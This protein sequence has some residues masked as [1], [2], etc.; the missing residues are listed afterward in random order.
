MSQV[1]YRSVNEKLAWAKYH[2]ELLK[3]EVERY[4][5]SNP[6]NAVLDADRNV[7]RAVVGFESL[8]PIPVSIPLT[9]GDCAQNLRSA[10]DYLIYEIVIANGGKPT[11]KHAFPV[12][13]TYDRFRDLRNKRLAGVP[14]STVTLIESLQPYFDGKPYKSD[15]LYIIDELANINKHRHIPVTFLKS[16][17][18]L[19]TS[20]A[21]WSKGGGLSMTLSMG[22]AQ[23]NTQVPAAVSVTDQPQMYHQIVASIAFSEGC[24]KGEFVA[25]V[26]DKLMKFVEGIVSRF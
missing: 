10:L 12:C 13:K 6:G 15:P 22:V 18:I 17:V 1:I 21:M 20:G 4:A 14:G 9:I 5:Q 11:E 7:N 23:A 3:S 16:R 19:G 25:E 26:L 24:A 2:F 8:H